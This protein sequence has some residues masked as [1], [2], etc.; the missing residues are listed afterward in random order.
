MKYEQWVTRHFDVKS[1]SGDERLVLCPFQPE[2]TSPHMYINV[3]KGLYYCHSCG[4]KGPLAKL[5]EGMNVPF[6]PS[7]I[8]TD[9]LKERVAG[10]TRPAQEPVDGPEVLSEEILASYRFPTRRWAQRGFSPGVV[11]LFELGYDPTTNDLTIPLR[12]ST[13]ELLG[14]IRRRPK[15]KMPKYMYPDGFSIGRYLFGAWLIDKQRT[16][17]LCEGPLDAV[18]CWDAG[19]PALGLLGARITADQVRVLARLNVKSTVLFLDN[20]NA[21]EIALDGIYGK[22]RNIGVSVKQVNYAA[23]DGKDPGELSVLR[24][25]ELWEDATRYRYSQGA[26]GKTL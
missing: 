18:A 8:P 4:V 13:G 21:G 14:V 16:V 11:D 22:L 15:G 23:Y 5:A 20:D 1:S 3:A 17:A 9:Y 12:S 24:R 19:I 7:T 2:K 25:T 26:V 6:G 10:L